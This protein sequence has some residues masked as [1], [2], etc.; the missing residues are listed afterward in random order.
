MIR[1]TLSFSSDELVASR[2]IPKLEDHSLSAV[3][4]P[5]FTIIAAISHIR[6]PF[7]LSQAEDVPCC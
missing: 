1:N 5:L 3:H 2:P 7:L 6:R 4:D